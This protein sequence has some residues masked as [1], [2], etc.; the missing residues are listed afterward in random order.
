MN[1][2]P[3]PLLALYFKL[4]WT[5]YDNFSFFISLF[6]DDLDTYYLLFESKI[7]NKSVLISYIKSVKDLINF[8]A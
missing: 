6:I 5:S 7:L 3:V 4:L 8:V 1:I 2:K